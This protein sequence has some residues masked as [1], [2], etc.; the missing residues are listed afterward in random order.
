MTIGSIKTEQEYQQALER[1]EIIFDAKKD[2]D[3]LEIIRM[4]TNQSERCWSKDTTT[5][6]S[7]SN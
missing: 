7:I 4:L 5:A 2:T 3:E 1:L 6:S